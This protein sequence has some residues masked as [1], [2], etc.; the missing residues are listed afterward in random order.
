M[1]A[2]ERIKKLLD[3]AGYHPVR[4]KNTEESEE[5]H[6]DHL[7]QIIKDKYYGDS[8]EMIVDLVE[9]VNDLENALENVLA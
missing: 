2:D 7:L 1:T 3:K 6:R 8:L 4:F 5:M 9:T